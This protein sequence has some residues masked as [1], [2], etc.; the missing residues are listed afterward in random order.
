MSAHQIQDLVQ[1]VAPGVR[2]GVIVIA[3][4]QFHDSKECVHLTRACMIDSFQRP[5][6]LVIGDKRAIIEQVLDN[7]PG[8]PKQRIAQAGFETLDDV[9]YSFLGERLVKVCDE[10][11]RFPVP[12]LETLC[13]EFFLDSMSAD[14]GRAD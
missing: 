9:R 13:V 11:F 6:R 2:F 7:T 1:G 4:A 12:F 8:I 5:R 14:T 3:T 10:G